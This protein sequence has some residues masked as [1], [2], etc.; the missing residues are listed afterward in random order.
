MKPAP[1]LLWDW[2]GTLLDDSLACVSALNLLLGRR[3][4]PPIDIG[5]YRREF[6]FPACGFYSRIGM[7]L[8]LEDWDALAK[9]YHDAY[10]EQPAELAPDAVAALRLAASLGAGQSIVSAL[11]QDHLDAAT[12]RFGVRGYFD[13]ICG[14]DNLDGA[15]K[16]GSAAALASRLASAGCR[17][18]VVIGDSL[19]DKEVADA[20]GARCVLYSGGSHAPERLAPHAPT[21]PSL[22]ECVRLAAAM[23]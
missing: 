1:Y 22:T 21:S 15:S 10:L 2:N 12:E 19:H 4:L 16:T 14:T 7:R 20:V 9:E 3:G 13:E 17:R 18:L 5:R 6:S 11:R 8:E 23:A